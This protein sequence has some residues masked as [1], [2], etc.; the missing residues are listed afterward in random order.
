MRTLGGNTLKVGMMRGTR[1]G[2]RRDKRCIQ[3]PQDYRRNDTT[4]ALLFGDSVLS[5]SK[6][7]SYSEGTRKAEAHPGKRLGQVSLQRLTYAGKDANCGYVV[8]WKGLIRFSLL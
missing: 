7:L 5:Q 8:D 3:S 2:L 1:L 6:K 4:V